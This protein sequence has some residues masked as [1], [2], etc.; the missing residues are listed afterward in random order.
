MV[1]DGIQGPRGGNR[2][3]GS[4]KGA[5]KGR[6]TPGLAVV[7]RDGFWHVVGTLSRK[8]DPR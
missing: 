2:G 7:E 3:G 8:P 6:R 1:G 4:R 5:A